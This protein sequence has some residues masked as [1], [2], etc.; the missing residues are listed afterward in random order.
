MAFKTQI[1]LPHGEFSTVVGYVLG[2][3]LMQQ[4]LL[5]A[6]GSRRATA[7]DEIQLLAQQVST[8]LQAPF[9]GVKVAFL[10]FASPTIDTIL[11]QCFQDGADKVIVLPYF[12]SSGNHV[13]VDVPRAIHNTRKKWPDKCIILLS[14][15]GSIETMPD[16]IASACNNAP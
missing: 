10:E 1:W 5:I 13:V 2:K 15:I 9:V 4:L 16:L 6:H 3:F 7:N 8:K 11:E 12:L 14:H